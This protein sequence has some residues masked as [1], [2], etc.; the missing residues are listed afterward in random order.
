MPSWTRGGKFHIYKQPCIILFI[1]WTQQPFTK[2]N[3]TLLTYENKRIDKSRIKIV[4]YVGAKAQA[5]KSGATL[6]KQTVGVIFNIQNSQLLTWSLP[7]EEIFRVHGQNRLEANLSAVDFRSQPRE[8]PLPKP[9]N[10]VSFGFSFRILVFF[11]Y[12]ESLN[13]TVCKRYWFFSV[14]AAIIH[15]HFRQTI[16][17]WE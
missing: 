10:N 15:K 3:S 14:L 8:M 2:K 12:K 9:L 11:L 5:E 1:I 16:L 7:I 6:Q 4:Q 17:D 13:V